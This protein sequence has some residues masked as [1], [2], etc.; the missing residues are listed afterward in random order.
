M[1]RQYLIGELSVRL[2]RLQAATPTGGSQVARLRHQVEYGPPTGLAETT[3]RAL[4]LA[5]W[6]CWQSLSHGDIEAFARQ[7]AVSAELR[8]FGLCASLLSE[9]LSPG[10]SRPEGD[11]D[12]S[13]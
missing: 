7:A 3:M 1:T 10:T 4:V 8:Q 6:L 2:E 11:G 13:G 5:D 12:G 9:W